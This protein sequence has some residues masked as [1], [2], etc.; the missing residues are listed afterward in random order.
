MAKNKYLL[1]V[2]GEQAEQ[3][4]I[5]TVLYKYGFTCLKTSINFND[6][7]SFEVADFANNDIDVIVA[8]SKQS[9]I[10]D[11]VVKFDSTMDIDRI[12]NSELGELF[13][14]IFLI[15]DVDHNDYEDLEKCMNFF[16]NESSG[17]LLVS[18]PCIE[19]LGDP[20]HNPI[21]GESITE[22]YKKPLNN[23][24]KSKLNISA[25][26]YIKTNFESLFKK[27]LIQNYSDFKEKNIMNHPKLIVDKVNKMNIRNNYKSLGKYHTEFK[28]RYFTTCIYVFVAFIFGLT[29]EENNY[30]K[31]L[32]FFTKDKD[33]P[34]F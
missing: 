5:A 8:T 29:I 7:G 31:V 2:E 33:N 1:I 3:Q 20:I 9:R 13:K 6:I 26:E 19:V 24:W 21:E 4:L 14:G 28:F 22:A 30:N 25:I 15:F 23:L 32:E 27:Y 12:F 18:S 17:L 10:H 16:N 34:V 11:I